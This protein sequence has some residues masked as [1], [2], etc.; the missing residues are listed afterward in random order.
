MESQRPV[1]RLPID[2]SDAS[3]ASTF[4]GTKNLA[5][6]KNYIDAETSEN[7]MVVNV[8]WWEGVIKTE[9]GH[10]VMNMV[11]LDCKAFTVDTFND[12]Y[13]D[14]FVMSDTGSARTGSTALPRGM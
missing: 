8:P 6:R 10:T 5:D 11:G 14:E 4:S 9:V 13:S 2:L 1:G 3:S 12:E 7:E